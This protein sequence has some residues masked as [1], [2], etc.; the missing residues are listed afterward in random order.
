MNNNFYTY[1]WLRE[2]GTPYYI[3]KGK[4]RRAFC[5]RGRGC[6]KPPHDRILILKK[7]LTEEEAFKHEVY[8]I[9]VFGRKDIGTG[10]LRNMCKGGAGGG[11]MAGKKHS[12]ETREKISRANRGNLG[13]SGQKNTT[14]H[15]LKIGRANAGKKRSL[16]QRQRL[17]EVHKGKKRKPL[18]DEV[19]EKIRQSLLGKKHSPERCENQRQAALRRLQGQND[20]KEMLHRGQ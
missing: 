12:E 16:E 9:A 8:M 15:N 6:K 18:S 1:A 14:E 20:R 5:N 7:D 11:A 19:K 17:S 13:R 4:G 2:D 10:I 3:G